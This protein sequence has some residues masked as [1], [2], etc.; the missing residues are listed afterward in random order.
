MGRKGVNSD[1]VE[2]MIEGM[3]QIMSGVPG[4]QPSLQD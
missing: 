4:Q 2:R 3:L 1:P